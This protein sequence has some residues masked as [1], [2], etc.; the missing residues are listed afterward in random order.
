MQPGYA[1]TT[2]PR[3]TSIAVSTTCV[4]PVVVPLPRLPRAD[5][6]V[7]VMGLRQ[8]ASDTVVVPIAPAILVAATCFRDK[9]NGE[10]ASVSLLQCPTQHF[11]VT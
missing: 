4:P 9:C 7:A 1:G 6:A 8:Y 11:D 10:I 2:V 3:T 5:V